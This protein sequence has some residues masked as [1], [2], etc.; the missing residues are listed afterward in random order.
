MPLMTWE[1]WLARVLVNDNPLAWQKQ[2]TLLTP[3]RVAQ[4]IPRILF[5]VST[6]A[7]PPKPRGKSSGWKTGQSRQR[8]TRYPIV[9]KRTSSS[10]KAEQKPALCVIFLFFYLV[11]LNSVSL[12]YFVLLSL[13]SSNITFCQS[14]IALLLLSRISCITISRS[15]TTIRCCVC[16]A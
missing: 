15:R 12:I 7:K 9:K 2:M 8:R 4:A 11:L 3:G 5:R 6:L 16:L 14:A 13:K 1:L 10:R